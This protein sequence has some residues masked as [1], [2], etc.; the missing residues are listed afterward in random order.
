LCEGERESEECCA[1]GKAFGA[2]SGF[3][4]LPWSLQAEN[5]VG[6][7]LDLLSATLSSGNR[8]SS[9]GSIIYQNFNYAITGNDYCNTGMSKQKLTLMLKNYKILLLKNEQ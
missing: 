5:A 9:T 3:T 1:R 6:F 2:E 4:G 7:C 8:I